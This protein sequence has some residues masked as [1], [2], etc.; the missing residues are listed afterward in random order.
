M[1]PNVPEDMPRDY[2]LLMLSCWAT[3]PADRP[4]ADRLLELL[5]MMLQERQE[6]YDEYPHSQRHTFS[7]VIPY[8]AEPAAGRDEQRDGAGGEEVCGERGRRGSEAGCA[9]DECSSGSSSLHLQ[10]RM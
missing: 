10:A 9:A 5:Q 1:R 7:R 2:S 4:T 8:P 6:P 3:S